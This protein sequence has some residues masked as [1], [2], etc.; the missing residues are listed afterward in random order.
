MRGRRQGKERRKEDG[1]D[2]EEEDLHNFYA[3]NR[4]RTQPQRSSKLSSQS[5]MI[6]KR[7]E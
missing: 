7:L 4:K 1:V 5:L 6:R 2:D 3:G